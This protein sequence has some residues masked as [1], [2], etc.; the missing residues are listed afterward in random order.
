MNPFNKTANIVI[1]I[2][3]IFKALFFIYFSGSNSEAQ[4]FLSR[5]GQAI[6]RMR[7]LPFTA[8]TQQVVSD[9]LSPSPYKTLLI[10][11]TYY[12]FVIFESCKLDL[13]M[14][15]TIKISEASREE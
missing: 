6:I 5:G 8:T 10:I 3:A 7:G 13:H 12:V 4:A 1:F 9:L 11:L 15:F 14:Y 2:A